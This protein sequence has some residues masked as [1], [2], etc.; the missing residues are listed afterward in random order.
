MGLT[1]YKMKS[2]PESDGYGLMARDA[3]GFCFVY[4]ANTGFWHRNKAREL[5]LAFGPEAVYEHIDGAVAGELIAGVKPADPLAMDRYIE[6][7]EQQPARW[8]KS[9]EDL[10]MIAPD[11]D[12]PLH[13]N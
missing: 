13:Q 7:L 1:L 4:S 9:S 6:E 8:I 3:D 10:G 5:D 2:R 11:A 12:Q